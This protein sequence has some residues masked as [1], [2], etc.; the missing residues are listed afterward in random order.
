MSALIDA[1]ARL[2]GVAAGQS[3]LITTAQAANVDVS[4]L[5]LARL[6]DRGMLERITHG[7]YAFRVSSDVH[8][9]IRAEWLALASAMPAWERLDAPQLGVASHTTAAIIHDLGD[10]MEGA[11]E[12]TLP[13]RRQSRRNIRLH[14]SDL[15]A[16]DITFVDGILVTTPERTIAD[17]VDDGHDLEHVSRVIRGALR[18]GKSTVE[19]IA[20][21]LDRHAVRN[22][23]ASGL[24]FTH[25]LMEVAGIDNEGRYITAR[26][27]QNV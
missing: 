22:G 26:G 17:L 23:H 13:T 14:R 11:P 1:A 25:F 27:G 2:T 6:V 20:E 15:P 19:R 9:T 18:H 12:F 7:V 10:F 4:R 24:A 8:A 21:H 16:A 3:G 5:E